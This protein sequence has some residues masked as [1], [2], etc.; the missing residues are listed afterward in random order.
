MQL[1]AG[2]VLGVSLILSASLQT[3][4][5][6]QAQEIQGDTGDSGEH[7][8]PEPFIERLGDIETDGCDAQWADGE[9]EAGWSGWGDAETLRMVVATGISSMVYGIEITPGTSHWNGISRDFEVNAGDY[10]NW[11]VPVTSIEGSTEVGIHAT[12]RNA[13]GRTISVQSNNWTIESEQVGMV[14]AY[15]ER[16]SLA[17]E[18]TVSIG[19]MS[20]SD[21]D[22]RVILGCLPG[23]GGCIWANG[24][25]PPPR[26]DPPP[27]E[28]CP[29]TECGCTHTC[30]PGEERIEICGV[31][32]ETCEV[33]EK[34][35]ACRNAHVPEFQ[36]YS[37]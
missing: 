8:S 12:F 16:P 7:G 28:P 36:D 13:S 23:L 19:A 11:T 5:S 37:P 27:K 1:L 24:T 32:P 21:L 2:S 14:T 10:V 18:V 33:G 9:C 30:A 26:S 6:A 29:N 4:A 25:E 3:Q 22:T 20:G 34:I 35:C 15:F 31:H 17:T